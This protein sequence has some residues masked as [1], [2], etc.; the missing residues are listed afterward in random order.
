MDTW[1]PN[2]AL[3]TKVQLVLENDF[4]QWETRARTT[5]PRVV[6]KH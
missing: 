2:W 1:G 6:A 3:S 4:S 5:S